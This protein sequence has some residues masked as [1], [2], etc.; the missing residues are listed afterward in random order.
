MNS[1]A[2]IAG[3]SEQAGVGGAR[4]SV[5]GDAMP[6]RMKEDVAGS[7]EVRDAAGIPLRAHCRMLFGRYAAPAEDSIDIC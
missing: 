2:H 7:G 5:Q 6:L 1:D 4:S 3:T